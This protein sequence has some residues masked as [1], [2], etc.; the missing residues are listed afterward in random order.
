MIMNK[1]WLSCL[2]N[3][4]EE[5]HGKETRNHIFG[6]IDSMANTPEYLSAWFKNLTNG[7]DELNDKAFLQQMM[8]T[9]CPCG[10]DYEKD[11]E[12]MK[13][14]YGKSDT[15]TEF[16]SNLK[17]WMLD[18][19]GDTDEMELRGNVLYMTKPLGECTDTGNCGRGCHCWLAMHTNTAVSDIFCHCCT[20]GHTGRP[21]QVAFGDSIKM[22]LIESIICGGKACIMTVH[23]PKKDTQINTPLH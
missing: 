3:D 8:A 2:A 4:I 20:I 10:G 18:K 21:F 6:D 11:G 16:V 23:L 19:Y 1:Q 14:I 7:L 15:L 13:E 12:A 17:K 9:H 22:E 5:R